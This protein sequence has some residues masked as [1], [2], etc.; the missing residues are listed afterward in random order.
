M[1]RREQFKISQ[2]GVANSGANS[3]RIFWGKS[4]GPIDFFA[5]LINNL[6]VSNS[7]LKGIS[8]SFCG[9]FKTILLFKGGYFLHMFAKW[10]LTILI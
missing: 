5:Y 7:V 6:Y 10:S 8:F 3:C 1:V 9:Q 2:K 4:P